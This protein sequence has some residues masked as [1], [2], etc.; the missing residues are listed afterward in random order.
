MNVMSVPGAHFCA[1]GQGSL[2]LDIR[3][4]FH[5]VAGVVADGEAV[6]DHVAAHHQV[7]AHGEALVS[8]MYMHV[9]LA[10]LVCP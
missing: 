6:P 8:C 3:S 2:L 4:R 1:Q 7:L 9:G 5:P 10:V